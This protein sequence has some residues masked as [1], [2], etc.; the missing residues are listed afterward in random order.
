M[1][2][3]STTKAEDKVEVLVVVRKN[4]TVFLPLYLFPYLYM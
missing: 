3:I 4:A 1:H 2:I